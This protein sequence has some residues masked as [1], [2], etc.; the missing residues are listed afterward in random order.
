MSAS[1]VSAYRPTFLDREIL[2]HIAMYRI[3]SY[4]FIH[5]GKIDIICKH[6]DMCIICSYT[7][8]IVDM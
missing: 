4:N 6:S 7:M 5:I 2:H 3:R 1:Y 8:R